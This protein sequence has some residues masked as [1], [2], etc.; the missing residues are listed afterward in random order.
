M[1]TFLDFLTKYDILNIISCVFTVVALVFT[2]YLWLLD[3]ISDDEAKFIEGKADLLEKLNRYLE[4]VDTVSDK[5]ELLMTV[6]GVNNELEVILKYRFWV[7]SK[8]KEKYKEITDFYHDSKYLIST[9]LRYMEYE[10]DEKLKQTLVWIPK[11]DDDEMKDIRDAYQK[12]LFFIK[13]F[14]EEFD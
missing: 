2:L 14:V 13:D 4:Y 11:M 7:R 10:K 12:G 5:E 1:A 3:K 8:Q 6:Q 9:I